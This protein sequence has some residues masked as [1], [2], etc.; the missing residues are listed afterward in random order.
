MVKKLLSVALI[1][2]IF[3]LFI[4]SPLSEARKIEQ[5]QNPIEI[6]KGL[7]EKQGPPKIRDLA[8]GW[9]EEKPPHSNNLCPEYD[10]DISRLLSFL[11]S[12]AIRIYIK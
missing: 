7:K 2:I 1:F 6:T 5:R 8:H 4:S 12:L 9:Q 11:T 10:S 3:F